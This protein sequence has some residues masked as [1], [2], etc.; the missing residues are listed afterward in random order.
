MPN[1]INLVAQFNP[2]ATAATMTMIRIVPGGSAKRSER[3]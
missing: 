2:K 3:R 1:Q